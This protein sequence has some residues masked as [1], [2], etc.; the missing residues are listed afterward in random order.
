M[1]TGDLR[2]RIIDKK[3]ERNQEL[4]ER[5]GDRLVLKQDYGERVQ[6]VRERV[7]KDVKQRQL[8]PSSSDRWGHDQYRPS[9]GQNM[10]KLHG[11]P[12]SEEE[13]KGPDHI[14][15][16][17]LN[18]VLVRGLPGDIKKDQ[19]ID[20]FGRYGEVETAQ[21]IDE[22]LAIVSFADNEGALQAHYITTHKKL[23]KINGNAVKVT[24]ID[25]DKK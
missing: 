16:K 5:F 21:I 15:N 3:H 17:Q 24:I 2:Q 20:L 8:D 23:L 7:G 6:S 14:S 18:K 1:R 19:V 13:V 10:D 11:D 22:G 9:S 12:E 25:E 4:Q